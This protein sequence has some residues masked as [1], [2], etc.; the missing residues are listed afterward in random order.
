[1]DKRAFLKGLMATAFLTA[2]PFKLKA[3][4]ETSISP[5]LKRA[6]HV[7]YDSVA[8]T[9]LREVLGRKTPDPEPH[10]MNSEEMWMKDRMYIYPHKMVPANP[11][12]AEY[13]L[14]A[15]RKD[16]TSD[17]AYMPSAD[18]KSEYY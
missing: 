6:F 18:G 2:I 15:D 9:Y 4:A 17:G 12:L 14:E 8:N 5:P 10:D 13:F 3:M 7:R 1:M 16:R 11:A